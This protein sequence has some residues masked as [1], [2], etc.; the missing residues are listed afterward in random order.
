MPRLVRPLM[1]GSCLARVRCSSGYGSVAALHLVSECRERSARHAEFR[2]DLVPITGPRLEVGLRSERG[3][4]ILLSAILPS[5]HAAPCDPGWP[6]TGL[7]LLSAGHDPVAFAG[8][9]QGPDGS[10]HRRSK[11]KFRQLH[12]LVQ[13]HLPQPVF[14]GGLAA[15]GGDQP[16]RPRTRQAAKG[17]VAHPGDLARRLP[18]AARMGLWGQPDPGGQVT[19]RP[20]LR[21]VRYAGGPGTRGDRPD[22]GVRSPAWSAGG[23]RPDPS[24]PLP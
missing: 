1:D 21:H 10:R 16:Q 9:E 24:G 11:G 20:D 5:S 4:R 18:V 15:A 19:R 7:V 8:L 14:S 23:A 2:V 6:V 12:R 17:A 22:P 13:Q 3:L